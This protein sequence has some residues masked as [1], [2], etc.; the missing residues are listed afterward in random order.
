MRHAFEKFGAYQDE[1]CFIPSR[2]RL[3]RQ[4]LQVPAKRTLWLGHNRW[5][6]EISGRARYFEAEVRFRV[7]AKCFYVSSSPKSFYVTGSKVAYNCNFV[8]PLI[9]VGLF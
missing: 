1:E 8:S 9:M 7:C 6:A 2:A 5:R 3:D 4:E